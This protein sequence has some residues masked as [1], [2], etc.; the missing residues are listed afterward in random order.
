VRITTIIPESH[1]TDFRLQALEVRTCHTGDGDLERPEEQGQVVEAHGIL[2][3]D[4]RD[5]ALR[6]SEGLL[7]RSARE[8]WCRIGIECLYKRQ[9]PREDCGTFEGWY[10]AV[11]WTR[12]RLR[13]SS[14]SYHFY[15]TY[16]YAT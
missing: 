4:T 5:Q 12:F 7:R 14:F 8:R 9:V 13:S 6:G 3:L 10:T 2:Y 16:F 15:V 11:N 1:Q